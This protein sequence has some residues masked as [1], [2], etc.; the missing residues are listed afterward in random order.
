M[1]FLVAALVAGLVIGGILL[2]YWDKI[3]D[4]LN[5]TAADTVERHLGYRARKAIVKAVSVADRVFRMLGAR[6]G[7]AHSLGGGLVT[8]T[9]A[10][11]F[12]QKSSD[13]YEMIEMVNTMT[14]DEAGGQAYEDEMQEADNIMELDYK[15]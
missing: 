1:F 11:I 5:T 10:T 13:E 3:K 15:A 6:S 2:K 7:T 9:V 8:S 12:S 14:A 4:W